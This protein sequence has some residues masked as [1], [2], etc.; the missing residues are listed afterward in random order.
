MPAD[1]QARVQREREAH[2]AGISRSRY[3][4][5]FGHA[6]HFYKRKCLDLITATFREHE[7]GH[8]L[9]LGS[10]SWQW[11]IE[12]F[13]IKPRSLTCINISEADLQ[14]GINVA[15]KSK[16]KADFRLMDAHKLDF[17]DSSFD[18]VYGAGILHHLEYE[19]AL[20][21]IRRVL[22]PGGAMLFREPLALNPVAMIVR[23]LTPHARTVDEQPLRLRDLALC[24]RLFDTTLHFEQL[25]S[26]PAGVISGLVQLKPENWLTR[27]AF[28][29][30]EAVL[31]LAPWM[32]PLCRMV[33]MIGRKQEH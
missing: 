9:E 10:I 29:T 3:D 5:A 8:F 20:L 25:F 30:D 15:A 28:V 24:R 1:L 26:I 12:P 21:E 13:G 7:A 11:W 33:L 17:P 4:R 2:N 14:K 18:V 16:T 19:R 6:E 22:K 31:K 32:G 23:W 27:S